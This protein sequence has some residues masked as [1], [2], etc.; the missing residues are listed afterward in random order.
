MMMNEMIEHKNKTNREW[1][2]NR[3]VEQIQKTKKYLKKLRSIQSYKDRENKRT[4]DLPLACLATSYRK[5]FFGM[6]PTRG[7]TSDTNQG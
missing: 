4:D 2:A 5:I 3:T 1:Y 6:H 7:N